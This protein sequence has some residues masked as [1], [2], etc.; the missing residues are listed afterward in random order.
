MAKI[1]LS[2]SKKFIPK[3][4]EIENKLKEKGYEVI[5]PKEFLIE[6]N[7]KE[8]SLLHFSEIEKDDVEAV[9]IINE[10]NNGLDNYI[11][12]NGF[13]ELALAFYKGKKVFLLNKIYKPYEEEII[14]W[15]IITLNGKLEN[16]YK[17]LN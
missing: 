8:A 11:G 3:F 15:G 14:G 10:K 5:V 9:I 17:Y 2:G 6:M 16:I 12:A 4:F 7:K 13:A 1:V